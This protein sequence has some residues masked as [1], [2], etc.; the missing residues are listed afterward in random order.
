MKR[1][2]LSVCALGLCL[3]LSACGGEGGAPFAPGEDASALLGSGAFSETL[4]AIDRD[5]ACGLYGI[6]GHMVS[7]CALY[8]ST[9]TT[10]QGLGI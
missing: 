3:A 7:D 6:G 10:A 4:E 9:G 2:V 1:I 5:V 8:G